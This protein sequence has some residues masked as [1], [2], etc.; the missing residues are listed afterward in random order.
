MQHYD[1][2]VHAALA[3]I[4]AT[5]TARAI[6]GLFAGRGGKLPTAGAVPPALHDVYELVTWL[7][8]LAP[9]P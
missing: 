5:F 6:G 4:E 8:M 3:S 2:L 1:T 9:A 7:V